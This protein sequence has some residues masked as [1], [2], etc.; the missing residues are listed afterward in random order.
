MTDIKVTELE[1]A[2]APIKWDILGLSEIR[3][4]G[5]HIEDRGNYIFYLYG[6]KKGEKGVGFMIKKQQHTIVLDFVPLSERVALLQVEIHKKPF[7]IVQ[8]YAPTKICS[9]DEIE[10]FY[11]TLESAM[12]QCHRNTI[13]MGDMNAKIGHPEPCEDIVMGPYGFGERNVRGQMFINF[14]HQHKLKVA[15]TMFKKSDELRWTW[16]HPNGKVRNEIDFIA[17]NIPKYIINFCALKN[18]L[19]PSD[20]RMIR[21]TLSIETKKPSRIHYQKKSLNF[22]INNESFQEELHT[23][24]EN[25]G[26]IQI[27]YKLTYKDKKNF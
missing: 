12:E 22:K 23:L 16:L 7:S 9:D 18:F 5:L 27:Y 10:D 2:L 25:E 6:I 19:H 8:I 4:E 24:L 11:K 21:V 26:T 3:R 14:C 1:H 13:L 20:H 15:N 17:T